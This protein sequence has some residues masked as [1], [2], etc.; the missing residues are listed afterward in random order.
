MLSKWFQKP[1]HHFLGHQQ[2]REMKG[3]TLPCSSSVPS[4]IREVPW[5]E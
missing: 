3:N 4:Q 2:N 5:K 1:Q